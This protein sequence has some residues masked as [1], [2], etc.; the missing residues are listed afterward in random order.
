MSSLAVL[1]QW[2]SVFGMLGFLK[3]AKRKRKTRREA[4][5]WY[6][7]MHKSIPAGA[8]LTRREFA[9]WRRALGPQRM[10]RIEKRYHEYKDPGG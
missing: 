7:R 5:E 1:T 2:K 8:G 10:V 4:L 6:L 3:T 9:S